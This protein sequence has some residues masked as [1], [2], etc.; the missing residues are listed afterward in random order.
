MKRRLV[1]SI[2][3]EQPGNK[4]IHELKAR[5][6]GI[7]LQEEEQ[8]A[9]LHA[10]IDKL[11]AADQVLD[12]HIDIGSPDS[13][14]KE[15][16]KVTA[17]ATAAQPEPRSKNK[18]GLSALKRKMLL[19][20]KMGKS[21]KEVAGRVHRSPNTVTT[22]LKALYKEYGVHKITELLTIAERNHLLD[23]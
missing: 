7:G 11:L 3:G 14:Y 2:H 15:L 17:K 10:Y 1:I 20:F 16:D 12:I 23:E 18:K 19:Y 4:N 21:A 22:H 8:R 5:R 6:P 9:M 13:F